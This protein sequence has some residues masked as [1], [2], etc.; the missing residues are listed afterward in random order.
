MASKIKTIRKGLTVADLKH[1]CWISDKHHF[2][3][4]YGL[5]SLSD[6]IVEAALQGLIDA[7]NRGERVHSKVISQT[8]GQIACELDSVKKIICQRLSRGELTPTILDEIAG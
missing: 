5:T 8:L 3:G 4:D 2:Q 7:A 6:S 1:G